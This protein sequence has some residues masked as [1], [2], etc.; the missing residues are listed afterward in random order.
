MDVGVVFFRFSRSGRVMD[1]IEA[2]NSRSKAVYSVFFDHH[3]NARLLSILLKVFFLS[4]S[5]DLAEQRQLNILADA[6]SKRVFKLLRF[7]LVERPLVVGMFLALR[8][9]M[10]RDQDYSRWEEQMIPS[11]VYDR[12]RGV[13][14]LSLVA[15]ALSCA[16]V[17]VAE[18][19]TS[20]IVLFPHKQFARSS[21]SS[22]RTF[23]LA[24]AFERT[25]CREI[26]R[27]M[28]PLFETG[29]SREHLLCQMAVATI[30][31]SEVNGRSTHQ[32]SAD[33]VV[34]LCRN[35][36]QLEIERPYSACCVYLPMEPTILGK[37]SF[38]WQ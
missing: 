13:A 10:D 8:L 2:N 7:S 22:F 15:M 29:S 36:I 19:Q 6:L 33:Q 5:V 26:S 12:I 31:W 21:D 1:A 24:S 4:V 27:K 16:K 9:L 28:P 3:P 35:E 17:Q 14:S 34:F 37:I 38:I 30:G 20:E 18:V 25:A 32:S 11:T 23:N